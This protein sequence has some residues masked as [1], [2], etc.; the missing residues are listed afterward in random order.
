M[1][2]YT[3]TKEYMLQYLNKTIAEV[4]KQLTEEQTKLEEAQT[5]FVIALDQLYRDLYFEL[6]DPEATVIVDVTNNALKDLDQYF[7]N[8]PIA[9]WFYA[10]INATVNNG[11]I[12]K[13]IPVKNPES[14][15]INHVRTDLGKKLERASDYLLATDNGVYN[16]QWGSDS[17]VNYYGT[18][19]GGSLISD[20]YNTRDQIRET[21]SNI[22]SLTCK[23]D[24]LKHELVVTQFCK[25]A[26]FEL[27]S[28]CNL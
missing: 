4:T 15:I 22:K 12:G 26:T 8:Q 9:K 13:S 2:T 14:C 16:F 17:V 7:A 3:L 1:T 27:T 23:L 11:I 18:V 28:E 20:C 25:S 5:A 10:L 19:K 21:N 24:I 6:H